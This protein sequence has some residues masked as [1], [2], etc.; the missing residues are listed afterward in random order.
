M[1][2]ELKFKIMYRNPDRE[3]EL[4]ASFFRTP[5][6]EFVFKYSLKSSVEFPG[7]SKAKREY[8]SRYLWEHITF[9]VPDLLRR[10]RGNVRPEELLMETKGRLVT[11]DFEF[12]AY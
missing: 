7:F 1:T 11:D 9:R 4:V 6:G 5:D 3:P 8:K 2:K 12:I 10:V